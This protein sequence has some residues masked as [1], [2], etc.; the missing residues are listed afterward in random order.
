LTKEKNVAI[1]NL[2]NI[3]LQCKNNHIGLDVILYGA[4][5]NVAS[6]KLE[7]CFS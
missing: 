7:N 4:L 3:F 1:T 5:G 2:E 6:Q